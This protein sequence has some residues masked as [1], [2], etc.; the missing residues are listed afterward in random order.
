MVRISIAIPMV[1][2]P[3]TD[4]TQYI[5]MAMHAKPVPADPYNPMPPLAAQRPGETDTIRHPSPFV[6]IRLPIFA[7]VIWLNDWVVRLL[8]VIGGRPIVRHREA[9]R[10]RG[11]SDASESAEGGAN[12]VPMEMKPLRT[13]TPAA[14]SAA[15]GTR[16]GTTRVNIGTR[17]KVD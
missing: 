15:K 10:P 14:P 7:V 9:P 3:N 6:P 16:V 5:I 17:R 1:Y 11:F 4:T 2:V 12:T 13:S 8:Q